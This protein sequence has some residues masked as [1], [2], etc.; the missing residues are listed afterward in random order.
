MALPA[1]PLWLVPIALAVAC[2]PR[3]QISLPTGPGA[4]DPAAL[5][6]YEAAIAHCR[7]VRTWSAEIAVAGRV[8]ERTVRLKV[9]AGT[10]ADGRVRLEG[11]APFGAP[12]FV[13]TAAGGN[14]ALLLPRE[15]RVLADAP[16][17]QLL[18]A[19]VGLPLTGED[20]HAVVSGCPGANATPMNGRNL[21]DGWQSVDVGA[22]QTA[23]LRDDTGL[24]RIAAARLGGITVAYEVPR[25]DVPRALRIVTSG[26]AGGSARLRLTVSQVEENVE[27]PPEAFRLDVPADARPI[28]LDELRSLTVNA[29]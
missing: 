27:L 16:I 28:T 2:A 10:T 9:L 23:Y 3:V 5:A 4:D 20:L 24:P 29:S 12:A 8:R 17:D 6:R 26:S 22:G 15:R 19:L 21:G 14:A 1:A 25:Q 13:L 7:Q 11:V 18:E